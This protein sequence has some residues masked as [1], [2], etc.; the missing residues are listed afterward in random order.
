M[1]DEGKLKIIISDKSVYPVFIIKTR[2]N[3]KYEIHLK[4]FH[5]LFEKFYELYEFIVNN[6]IEAWTYRFLL[7]ASL[8]ST[9]ESALNSGIPEGILSVFDKLSLEFTFRLIEQ[10][11]KE[12][13]G[14]CSE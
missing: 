13:R 6:N 8:V 14:E 1:M 2:D 10:L 4:N 9:T 11:R 12:I 5:R 7:L 3:Q